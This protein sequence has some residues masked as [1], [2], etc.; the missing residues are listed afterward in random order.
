MQT[1]QA[2]VQTE[3]FG[4]IAIP[5]TAHEN[6]EAGLFIHLLQPSPSKIPPKSLLH[7]CQA[8]DLI[9]LQFPFHCKVK[10][11]VSI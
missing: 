1:L 2:L 4:D 3:L 5:R 6:T 8:H 11:A 9:H 7:K 10:I